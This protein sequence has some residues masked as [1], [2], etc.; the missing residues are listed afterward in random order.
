MTRLILICGIL[1]VLTLGTQQPETFD[2]EQSEAVVVYDNTATPLGNAIEDVLPQTRVGNQITLEG[3]ARLLTSMEFLL[4]GQDLRTEGDTRTVRYF[5]RLTLY[6]PDKA[7]RPD[8]PGRLIWVTRR[9]LVTVDEGEQVM[10]T[11][12]LP[13]V[14]VPDEF[15]WAITFSGFEP[16]VIAPSI[17]FYGPPTVGDTLED[18][19][20]YYNVLGRL[21]LIQDIGGISHYAK[22]YAVTPDEEDDEPREK[23][24]LRSR[25]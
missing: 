13:E 7:H 6:D 17:P 16:Y 15:V 23:P 19:Y 1:L 4:G 22:A 14:E 18:G 20:W 21:W 8:S 24:R 2:A 25:R 5:V 10:V 9:Q 3:D 12:D 11:F